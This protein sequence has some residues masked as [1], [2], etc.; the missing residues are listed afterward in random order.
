MERKQVSSS[1]IR[2]VGYDPAARTLQVEFNNGDVFD[3]QPVPEDVYRRM[4]SAT[5]IASFFE[6]RI[7]EEYSG[8]RVR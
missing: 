1:R 3:Y 2:S 6:D 8:R 4:M 7:E 5:S